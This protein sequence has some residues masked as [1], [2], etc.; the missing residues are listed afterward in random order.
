MPTKVLGLKELE[1]ALEQIPVKMQQ[2]VLRSGNRALGNQFVKQIR[3][4]TNLPAT[5]RKAAVSLP[6]PKAYATKG[7]LVGLRKPFSPLAHL[8]EF[9][10]DER[11]QKKTG[12]RTGVMPAV[13]FLRPV[14][15]DLGGGKAAEIWAKAA[16]R[17]FELQMRKLARK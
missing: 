8:F 12:R 7:Y 5:I 15:D 16:S 3:S 17:N 13:P 14:L 10:T 6:N 1:K 9:G 2:H 4:N 11:A